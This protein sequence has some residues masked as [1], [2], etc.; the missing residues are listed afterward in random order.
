MT[1]F[2]QDYHRT[3]SKQCLYEMGESSEEVDVLGHRCIDYASRPDP[4]HVCLTVRI[5]R[6]CCSGF[7]GMLDFASP[8]LRHLRISFG[9]AAY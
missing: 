3:A 7:C 5:Q 4:H 8:S 1:D 2:F 9:S 6:C